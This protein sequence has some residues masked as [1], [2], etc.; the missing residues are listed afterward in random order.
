MKRFHWEQ[1]HD[2]PYPDWVTTLRCYFSYRVGRQ[3]RKL[4]KIILCDDIDD[5]DN[6]KRDFEQ[7]QKH[8]VPGGAWKPTKDAKWHFTG[9]QW[10]INKKYIR[11]V[12]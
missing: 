9:N 8:V 2:E 11:R 6:V 7:S 5:I 10:C 12:V 3:I 1:S 4:C